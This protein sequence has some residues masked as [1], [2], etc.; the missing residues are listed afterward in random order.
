[1]TRASS[2]KRVVRRAMIAILA[3]AASM[4]TTSRVALAQTPNGGALRGQVIDH[5]DGAGVFGA[6]VW[7]V[8]SGQRI[9]TDSLGGF[10]FAGLAPGGY[11][12]QIRHIGF[13]VTRDTVS[14]SADH[15][16][17]RTYSLNSEAAALDTVRTVA[18]QR[19]YVSPR[20]RAFEE[21]RLSGQG[22]HFISD[23]VFHRN[24]NTTMA[25]LIE[26]RMPGL[27][28]V[29]G[30]T[31]ASTRKRCPGL[32][33]QGH[34]KGMG[35]YVTIYVDGTLY[36]TPPPPL[37]SG[38][39]MPPPDF[40]RA[41]STSDFSGAEFYADGASAPAGMHSNDQGCGTLWLWTRER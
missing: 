23:S 41:F 14:V 26:S 9:L 2:P 10:L 19:S 21:R 6:E 30:K 16:T 37:S 17:V 4:T 24:E 3:V 32:A 27:T 18:K 33:F 29:E 5:K 35:C 40:S 22:G 8:P 36:Y 25:N 11:I 31:L 15:E 39:S 38:A 28:A 13:R 20:L 12:I 7:L 1:M 34:C